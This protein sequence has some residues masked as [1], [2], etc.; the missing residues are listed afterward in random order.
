MGERLKPPGLNPGAPSWCRE[1]KSLSL[2][3]IDSGTFCARQMQA[4]IGPVGY[5]QHR[6]LRTLLLI[7]LPLLLAA[8][9]RDGVTDAE[10][11][12]WQRD[13]LTCAAERNDAQA[14]LRLCEERLTQCCTSEP[15]AGEGER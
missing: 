9:T 3:C 5:G 15:T 10:C 11:R 13:S 1:F 4:P 14:T 12:E 7:W 2:L 8:C 6:R